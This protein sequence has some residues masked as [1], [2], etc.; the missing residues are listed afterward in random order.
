M[1]NLHRLRLLRE[2]YLQ[3]SIAKAAKTS[4]YS[5]SVISQHL[6]QLQ[7]EVGVELISTKDRKATLTDE[8]VFLLGY[9]EQALTTLEEAESELQRIR[10]EPF[11]SVRVAAPSSVAA[12]RLPGLVK[13]VAQKY[14]RVVPTFLQ[15]EAEEAIDLVMNGSID[16]AVVEHLGYA[17]I[18]IDASLEKRFL[19]RERIPAFLPA[20]MTPATPP[21]PEQ[22]ADIPWVF[23]P[24]GSVGHRWATACCVE[25]GFQPKVLVT[26]AD[27]FTHVRFIESGVAAGFVPGGLT[28]DGP[29]GLAEVDFGSVNTEREL[30][31]VFRKSTRSRP[32]IIGMLDEI[33]RLFASGSEAGEQVPGVAVGATETADAPS[34]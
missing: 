19:T 30:Y 12:Y 6:S 24:E 28:G 7:R 8:A 25:L 2:V 26:S 15:A 22:L 14:P 17:P 4:S 29:K 33:E 11:G 1:L 5:A 10:E 16:I 13:S 21:T 20:G 32:A 9:V 31:Y 23:E 27:L 34:C 18:R 3:G